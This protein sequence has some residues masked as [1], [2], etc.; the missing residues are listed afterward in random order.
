MIDE[1]VFNNKKTMH[2][3]VSLKKIQISNKPQKNIL[4]YYNDNI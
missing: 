2:Q 3:H 4:Y 1:R